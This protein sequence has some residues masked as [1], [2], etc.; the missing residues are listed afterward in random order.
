MEKKE[1]EVKAREKDHRQG[2][3]RKE[4]EQHGVLT[5]VF[6]AFG[7]MATMNH[8]SSVSG[9]WCGD[10]PAY[11]VHSSVCTSTNA[12]TTAV[13]NSAIVSAQFA[14]PFSDNNSMSLSAGLEICAIGHNAC[15][16]HCS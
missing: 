13:R 12:K 9:I 15:T 16:L 5:K 14:V 1:E 4:K 2:R 11:F 7:L 3:N 6:L 10:G 8:W